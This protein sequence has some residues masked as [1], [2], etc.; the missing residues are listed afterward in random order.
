MTRSSWILVRPD[1]ILACALAI[2]VGILGAT[3]SAIVIE[4]V[5]VGNL[6]NIAHPSN[7]GVGAVGYQYNIGK[8]EV[9]AGEYTAF[10]TAMAQSDPNGLYDPKMSSKPEGPQIMRTGASGSYQY[11]VAAD[12]EN[13]PMNYVTFLQAM[14]FSNWLHNDQPTGVPQNANST[15]NGAYD[16]SQSIWDVTRNLDW[17]WAFNSVDEWLKAGYHKNN[18]DTDEY[19]IYPTSSDILPGFVTESDVDANGKV[20]A[21][22]PGNTATWNGDGTS[23]MPGVEGIGFP[24]FRTEVGEHENSASPYG[25]FDQGGNLWEMTDSLAPNT[26]RIRRGG[27]Y[28]HGTDNSYM[29]ASFTTNYSPADPSG[30]RASGFRVVS[31]GGPLETCATGCSWTSSEGG[32]WNSDQNWDPGA[33]PNGNDHV[34]TFG[35]SITSNST[36]FVDSP[37]T[38]NRIDFDNALASYVIAGSAGVTLQ[39]DGVSTTPQINVANGNHQFQANVNLAAN[40][41]VSISGGRLDF[42]NVLDLGGNT[43]TKTGSGTLSINNNLLAS[44]GGTLNCQQG[45]C[46]GTGTISGDVQNGGTFSPGNSPGVMKVSGDF[47]QRPDG[48]LLIELAGTDAGSQFDQLQVQ[49]EASLDGTLEVS[50]LDGFAPETGDRFDILDFGQVSGEFTVLD[51]PELAAGLSWDTSALYTDGSLSVVPEPQTI[52]LLLV[53]VLASVVP[54]YRQYYRLSPANGG[55]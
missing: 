52:L 43:L 21:A 53:A 2:S 49:G 26:E 8:Y 37:V 20:T 7:G 42:N 47:D 44:G 6:G 46:G 30:T 1:F 51:V 27:N 23:I 50:L 13:R 36:V 16:L 39:E 45:P 54:S 32:N 24:W 48:T 34:V 10:L 35:S 29:E 18:G 4:T 11:N 15:E 25:T 55:C 5:P 40:T 33:L 38:V 22:D 3:A 14:R 19:F 31:L 17:K 28:A 41:D 12:F 9:T